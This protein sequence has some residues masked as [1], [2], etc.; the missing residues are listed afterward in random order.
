MENGQIELKYLKTSM[1]SRFTKT[2]G[3][4]STEESGFI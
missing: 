3:I 4:F 2:N 1:S